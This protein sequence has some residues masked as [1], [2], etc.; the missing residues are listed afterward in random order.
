MSFSPDGQCLATA[1]EDGTVRLWRVEGL[2]ELLARGCDWLKDYLA[3]YPKVLKKLEVCQNRLKSIEVDGNL[4]RVG[5]VEGTVTNPAIA[6]AVVPD[7]LS[8]ERGVDYTRLRDLLAAGQWKEADR[9]TQAVMLEA[10]GQDEEDSLKLE[11]EDIKNFPCTD[12]RTIDHLWVKYSQGR[13][14]FSIQQRI[15]QRSQS[16]EETEQATFRRFSL[17]VGWLAWLGSWVPYERLLF[18]LEAPEGHLPLLHKGVLGSSERRIGPFLSRVE[19]CAVHQTTSVFPEVKQES[20][21]DDLNSEREIDYTPLRELLRASQWQE[22]DSE[23]TAIA[24]KIS[25]REAEGWL[26]EEDIEK[27][28]CADL[29]TIDQLWVKYSNRRFGFSVQKDIWQSVGGMKNAD[30]EVYYSFGER[31]KWR[32]RGGLW[33]CHS[34]LTFDT[35][36]PVGHLPGGVLSWLWSSYQEASKLG[37]WIES[38]DGRKYR[39][40]WNIISSLASRLEECNRH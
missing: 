22:A 9:E 4:A 3:T 11:E 15:W 12:L 32:D 31:V 33:L 8:S 18:N 2:D 38:A 24:L 16:M 13:F 10:A 26:R 23:T 5:D 7:D 40:W 28:P 37:L 17:L 1:G 29:L 39:V 20:S 14:G 34:E 25:G 36:A 27:F 35:W 19:T 30:Y 21:T 6:E